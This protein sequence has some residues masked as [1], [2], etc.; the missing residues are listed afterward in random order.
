MAALTLDVRLDGFAD[1]VHDAN[2]AIF[3]GKRRSKG[4]PSR[5]DALFDDREN[6][7]QVGFDRSSAEPIANN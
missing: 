6:L 1:I 7:A 3:D 4:Q 2:A 5:L